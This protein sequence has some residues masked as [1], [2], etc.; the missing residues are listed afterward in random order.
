MAPMSEYSECVQCGARISPDENCC[1]V[2]GC[3]SQTQHKQ[4]RCPNCGSPVA[5]KATTCL[6]CG[7]V[8]DSRS[9]SGLP[10][11][12]SW[13]RLVLVA[14]MGVMLVVGWLW[15]R[16]QAPADVEQPTRTALA[17]L[18]PTPTATATPAP[19]ATTV[20]TP[21]SPPASPTPI[22]HVVE[23]GD[24]V[25]GIASIYGV[26]PESLM[27]AND[28]TDETA[29]LLHSGQELRIPSGGSVGGLLSS[30]QPA[31]QV[32]H[33]VQA[34]DTIGS[35]AM[36]Y[37]TAMD[38]ILVANGMAGGDLIYVG[39]EIVVPLDPP[40]PTPTPTDTPTPTPTPGPPFGAPDL[41]MPF[42]G[43]QFS[44]S[45]AEIT[46]M[47]TS[48][49]ILGKDQAYLVEI[50]QKGQSQPIWHTTQATS[51]RLPVETLPPG[52]NRDFTWFVMVV[53][54]ASTDSD[55]AYQ[56]QPISL[57]SETRRFTWR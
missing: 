55:E 30:M 38:V 25:V 31:H 19:T 54:R 26:T 48:V 21:T 5:A 49:G 28:L 50:N 7:A 56:W 45:Q 15:W 22:I 43:Q 29:R 4:R 41:L 3:V 10:A 18:P 2:C 44:A 36:Q 39:Q 52:A 40:T 33:V 6:T 53:Q 47:W 42:Q 27:E 11:Y 1:P 17:V 14:L 35:I 16:G 37:D 12:L 57:P 23:A 34:G 32:I 8:L 20:P 9:G 51:W 46:L 13:M 24:T